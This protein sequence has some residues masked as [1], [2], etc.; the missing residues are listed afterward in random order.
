MESP[1]SAVA[2]HEIQAARLRHSACG[3]WDAAVSACC[4][5]GQ[6][7]GH[8]WVGFDLFLFP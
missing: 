3:G 1:G 5:C 2:Q 8:A 7:G 6:C 4:V